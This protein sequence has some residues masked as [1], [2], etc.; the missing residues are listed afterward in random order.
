MPRLLSHLG[1][2]PMGPGPSSESAAVQLA[3]GW[4]AA[5]AGLIADHWK[6]K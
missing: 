3:L 1:L 4:S 5:S 2:D 6:I